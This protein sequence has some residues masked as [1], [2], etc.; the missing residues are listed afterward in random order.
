M[1][2]DKSWYIKP[3]NPNFSSSVAA[4]GIVVRKEKGKFLVALIGTDFYKDYMFPKGRQ[5]DGEEI[6]ITAR[7]EIAEETGLSNLK[8]I[9]ELGITERLSFEKND[10]KTIHYY[11]FQTDDVSGKQ[12]LQK[13]EEE[14]KLSWFDIDSLPLLF[15]PEQKELIEEN[16]KRIK[17]LLS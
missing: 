12:N 15:W 3:K 14:L 7:R 8:L 10:W 16:K 13:G 2:I 4:G 11:L 17:N 5:E 1:K 9:C 6:E